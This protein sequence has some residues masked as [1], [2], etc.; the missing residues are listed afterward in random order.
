MAFQGE[1]FPVLSRNMPQELRSKEKVHLERIK[2]LKDQIAYQE[3]YNRC[4]T[5]RFLEVP[6][7]IADEEDTKKVIYQLLER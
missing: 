4:E 5:L 7:S 1:K 6:E 2:G 3:L